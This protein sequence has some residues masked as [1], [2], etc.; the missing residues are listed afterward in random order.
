MDI[1]AITSLLVSLQV[2]YVSLVMKLSNEIIDAAREAGNS[3]RRKEQTHKMAEATKA[4]AHF[5]Y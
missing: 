5:R 1:R 3:I 4:F 2:T